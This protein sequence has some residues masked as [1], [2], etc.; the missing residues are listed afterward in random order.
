MS[1]WWER[2]SAAFQSHEGLTQNIGDLIAD[3]VP[4]IDP[5]TGRLLTEEQRRADRLAVEARQ[6]DTLGVDAPAGAGDLS[7][8]ILGAIAREATDPLAL[9]TGGIGAGATGLARLLQLAAAGGVYEGVSASAEQ[10]SD[11]GRITSPA[12]IALRTGAG[13]VLTPALDL[14]IRGIGVG[15][16]RLLERRRQPDADTEAID[17]DIREGVLAAAEEGDRAGVPRE[18]TVGRLIEL[19]QTEEGSFATPRRDVFDLPAP[20]EA[21]PEPTRGFTPVDDAPGAR[22]RAPAPEPGSPEAADAAGRRRANMAQLAEE[23]DRLARATTD[24]SIRTE[25]LRKA[26]FARGEAEGAAPKLTPKERAERARRV[27]P[28]TD[29]IDVAIRKLGGIDTELE[30]DWAGRLVDVPRVFGLPALERPGKGLS[31]DALTERLYELGY[32]SSYDQGELAN[33]LGRVERGETVLSSQASGERFAEAAGLTTDRDFRFEREAVEPADVDTDFVI[34]T[35]A[36]TIVPAR[37]IDLEDLRRLEEEEANARA[38]FDEEASGAADERGGLPGARGAGAQERLA[39]PAARRAGDQPG[40]GEALELRSYDDAELRAERDRLQRLADEEEAR[41]RDAEARAAADLERDGFTLTGSDRTADANPAQLDLTGYNPRIGEPGAPDVRQPGR[42]DLPP[43]GR[44]AD[45]VPEQQQ[46]ELFAREGDDTA[47]AVA[48]LEAFGPRVRYT[49]TSRLATGTRRV[50]SP[51][52]AAH[53]VAQ[54]R[55]EPQESLLAIVTDEAGDVLRIARHTVGTRDSSQVDP[56]LLAAAAHSTRGGRRVWFV[57]QHPS[58]NVTQSPADARIT[59]RLHELLRDTGVTPEGMV[60]V[61]PGG[62]YSHV[63]PDPSIGTTVQGDRIPAAVRSDQVDV[64]ERRFQRMPPG[65]EAVTSPAKMR[66]VLD[67]IARGRDGVLLLDNQH[68]PVGFLP[69]SARDMVRLRQGDSSPAAELF[70]A[71][72]ETN[73]SATAAAIETP[74]VNTLAQ[75]HGNLSAFASKADRRHLDTMNADGTSAASMSPAPSTP[76][77]FYANPFDQAIRFGARTLRNNTA[78]AVPGGLGGGMA[79]GML[80]DEEPGS[81]RWWVDVGFGALAGALASS[82]LFGAARRANIVGEGSIADLGVQRAGTFLGKL[83][84]RGPEALEN[85]K[86]Q[87]RLMRQLLDRQAHEIGEFLRDNFTPSERALMSDLIENRG[88]V[89]DLNRVHRQAQALDE[90]LSFITAKHKEYGTLPPGVEEGGYLHRYYAKHLGIDKTFQEAKR[91]SLSGSYTIARGMVDT[92]Q[93]EY[94]SRGVTTIVDEIDSLLSEKSFLE[95]GLYEKAGRVRGARDL[96]SGA[97]KA[98]PDEAVLRPP[99]GTAGGQPTPRMTMTPAEAAR[100]MV[101]IDERLRELRKIDL[102]EMVGEQN[103]RPR[104]FFFTRDEVGRVDSGVDPVLA[105]MQRRPQRA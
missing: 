97:V 29:A 62:R 75:V 77:T 5:A 31:L 92:F 13:A 78:A 50:T 38:Y 4:E 71:L 15:I 60:V 52:D 14:A 46:L 12:E 41:A 56:G 37:P 9:L 81:A 84:G 59:E 105:R 69:M 96:D 83:L 34:D 104:A 18:E 2:V 44:R 33:L 26:E 35:D 7:A 21:A 51:G 76:S 68:V 87:Q 3:R 85:A 72:D 19:V 94:L 66:E 63:H 10:L 100:R 43:S 25:L 39:D 47:Q 30:T 91:Q 89:P 6:R 79:G 99:P 98:L 11:S 27:D 45:A 58:G 65:G 80:S 17:A 86:R 82:G 73:A 88:I 67:A 16:K 90:F 23:Y 49:G 48:A 61:A 101:E 1:D 55:K 28:A 8:D 64:E 95:R 36:G 53:V 22:P 42:G 40:P 70:R 24:P 54:L 57:H 103:G 93:R 32:L 74:D 102:V 20:G